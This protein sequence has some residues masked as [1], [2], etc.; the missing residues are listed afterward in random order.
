LADLLAALANDHGY[1]AHPGHDTDVEITSNP[2]DGRWGAGP[3]RAE[4]SAAVRVAEGERSVYFWETLKSRDASAAGAPLVASEEAASDSEATVAGMGPGT[5]SWEWGHGTLR[6][7]VEDVAS[8][9]GFLMH[10]VLARSSAT[11]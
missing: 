11:W 3:D 1:R 10:P 6:T 8:R 4:Y 2:V 5:T 7:V 9:H